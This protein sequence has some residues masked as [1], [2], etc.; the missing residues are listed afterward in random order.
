MGRINEWEN[1]EPGVKRKVFAPGQHLM[2]MEVH[3]E[4]GAEGYLHRHVHEQLSYCLEGKLEFR[5]NGEITLLAAGETILIP[6]NAEHGC[7][8]L[9]KSRLLDTFTPLREDLLK[10]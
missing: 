1:A 6:S 10:E 3:F 9:T 4:E 8:A 2:M 5:I 7:R